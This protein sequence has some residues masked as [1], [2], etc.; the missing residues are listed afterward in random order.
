MP[1]YET[2]R[3]KLR[4]MDYYAEE[5]R[6]VPEHSS[7]IETVYIVENI[8]GMCTRVSGSR[9][10]GGKAVSKSMEGN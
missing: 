3:A 8:T 1:S 9:E 7:V 2:A 5:T 10:R 6:N 4:R